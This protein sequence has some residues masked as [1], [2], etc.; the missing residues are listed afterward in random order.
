M[1]DTP[2][3]AGKVPKFAPI[4]ILIT[5]Q[6]FYT[7]IPMIRSS[8]FW[9]LAVCLFAL[10]FSVLTSSVHAKT[11]VKTRVK[12][13]NVL[14]IQLYASKQTAIVGD[15]VDIEITTGNFT[16]VE[17]MTIP[18]A[19]NPDLLTYVG[20]RDLSTAI[21]A[22]TT[23]NFTTTN[24]STGTLFLNWSG[25]P[26]S[27]EDGKPFFT[28]RFTVR[29]YSGL[30]AS[31]IFNTL[32]GLAINTSGG[33]MATITP[34]TGSV[35]ILDNNPCPPRAAGLSCQ[36]APVLNA[37]E[38]PYYSTLPVVPTPP[39]TPLT[40]PT[41]SNTC[42]ASIENNHWVAF[43]AAS[44]AL[45]L[46]IGAANSSGGGVQFFIYETNDCISFQKVFCHQGG[47]LAGESDTAPLT[48]LTIGKKYYIML[49]GQFGDRCDYT[50]AI[51]SGQVENYVQSIPTPTILGQ[52][53]ACN[54]PT[55]LTYSIPVVASAEKYFWRIP[56]SATATTPISGTNQTSITVNWG[57]VSDSVCV[58]IASRCDLS[59]WFCKS[60]K[61]GVKITK[62][63]T[64]RKCT[65][66][67]YFFDGVNRF[68]A[69]QYI[70]YF[71]ASSGCD[72]VVTLTLIN[73]PAIVKDT[74]V[75]KCAQDSYKFNG[76]NVQAEGNYEAKFPTASGCDSTVKLRLFN[77][78]LSSKS[79]DTTICSGTSII[80]GG[81]VFSAPYNSAFTALTR[82]FQGCDSIISLK[83]TVIDFLL[84]PLIKSNEITCTT[85]QATLTSVVLNQPANAT[86]SYSWKN[87]S[88]TVVSTAATATVN[89][90]GVFTL[91]VTAKVND[92]LCSK[93]ASITVTKSGNQ[94]VKPTIVG[95]NATCENSTE[96]YTSAPVPSVL[97]YNWTNSNGTFTSQTNQITA[98]WNANATSSKVCISAQNACGVSD[99]ACVSVEIGRTPQPLSI[100]GST[101]VCPNATITYRVNALPNT[102]LLWSVTG[103][104]AQNALTTDSLWVR[105]ATT[106][107]R[108]TLTPS[109]RCGNG[110]PTNLD[111]QISNIIPDSVP[112][113][114]IATPCS[115]DTTVYSVANSANI[116]DYQW[117]VPIGA[118]I[119]RGQGTRSITVVWGNFSG[120]GNVFL[121]SKNACQLARGVTFPVDVKK[122]TLPT[123]VI[124][125]N[126]T[127]CPNTQ[128]SFATPRLADIRSYAWT[129]PP[130]ATILRGANSDSIRVDWA[131]A[132]SG[133]VCLEIVTICGAKQKACATI[134]VR[135]DLDSLVISGGSTACKDSILRFC[136]PDDGSTLRFLWQI[137][138]V[139]GGTIVSGQGTSCVNIRFASS[140]G[141]VRV[142]P[143]GGCSDG[144]I[145][146]KEVGV[147]TPPSI[148]SLIT[149]KTTVCNNSVETFSVT[150]QTDILRYVWRLPS[151][152][153]FM[154]DST[155]NTLTVKISNTAASGFL[156]VQGESACGLSNGVTSRLAV[157]QRPQ[158]NAGKDTSICNMT[159]TLK[160]TTNGTVKTWSV[161]SK[162][163]GSVAT[164]AFADRSQTNVTVT[165]AGEYVFKF[166]ESNGGECSMAD[167]ITVNFRDVPTATLVDQN[168]NQE[169]TQYRVQL[170]VSG[171][172]S[173]FSIGGSVFGRFQGVSFLSDTIPSGTPYF[174][175]ITDAF[176]CKSDTVKGTK[177]CPCYTSAGRLK[178]DSLVVC[179]GATGKAL[180]QG[181]AKLDVN[182]VSEYFLHTGSST[183]IGNILARNKTGIFSF[184]PNIVTYNRVYYI[185]FVVGDQQPNGSIDTS[186]RCVSQTLGIPIIFKEQYTASLTGDT[187]VCR[188]SPVKLRFNSSQT[189][190]FD[191]N[192]QG[193][194]GGNVAIP[195]VQSPAN[196]NVNTSLSATYKLIS[197]IDKNGCRAQITDSARVNL[198]PLPNANAGVDRSVC[199]TTVQMEAAENFSYTG[200]W[201]SLTSNVV[202]TDPTD[203]RSIVTNLQNGR[204][205]FVWTVSDT[206]CL[207]YSVRDTV[208]I[209]VPLLPKANNLSLITQI[210]VPV[211]GNVSESAPIGTY[212]VTRLSNPTSGRFDLFS[213]GAFTYIPD[214]NFEG[215][216]KFRYV[217][218]S[219]LCTR[220]CD[221]GEVR[222][223]IQ[224]RKDT[225]KFIK[226]DVPNAITPN[227]DGKNDVLIIDGLDQVGENELVIF[228]RWGDVLYK[229]KPYKN[230]WRG[231][232]QSGAALPEGTY[233]YVLRL[234]T[235]DGKI[236]R[237]DIT[238]L[239]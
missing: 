222:I 221:T 20:V 151:G 2:T 22:F 148:T 118:T 233:Y 108:V 30:P 116:L 29:A 51:T 38:F 114:G 159:Y 109:S 236:L 145:S 167:S 90:G 178:A 71:T 185:T 6:N 84:Q 205:I 107:G 210:G 105:W 184:D 27:I 192:Y 136:V 43:T 41:G 162:P 46:K 174:F 68:E 82:S 206:A 209:F 180:P 120:Y 39:L 227:D 37:S 172:G 25:V 8:K 31:V 140:G 56:S 16:N 216:V 175:I 203:P 147:K 234:N 87:A 63:T 194:N 119:L 200:K 97:S 99:T 134:E 58:R 144:K 122:S 66:E 49:D 169:A 26:S 86:L 72:S 100:T 44:T 124:N 179:F 223:L 19:W 231:T 131:D 125:G 32:A 93:T 110:T 42:A 96:I 9:R 83:V 75:Y 104:T 94:P 146:R 186:K 156:T 235:A 69:K 219:D 177:D 81:R 53:L 229:S 166:E 33:A 5:N 176:G 154:G 89:Q 130:T 208:Q 128:I 23:A 4:L 102:T 213:N 126:R 112:I 3:I 13:A 47:I 50:I 117:Q 196:I 149:G 197:V 204:N 14:D 160:G 225:A 45:T 193:T 88:G 163:V 10:F 67:P 92:K 228:N 183:R 143:V 187:T 190:F 155:T 127:V 78:P 191:I 171:T 95:A 73:T 168:C 133:D 226:I 1:K 24:T 113:Q 36:T 57:T 214:P 60:V 111:V 40:I 182:D 220:L 202:I 201:S 55:G 158:V 218:C 170:N 181:D 62:D 121:T 212:S 74:T 80:I 195:N 232:N 35:R 77:Y 123:S 91:T 207:G 34:S 211:T 61:A 64:V 161:V 153:T 139:L 150:P 28:I 199:S 138:T 135:A 230:E 12:N 129:V 76:V 98:T 164:F 70:G 7:R 18:L 115:N 132:P 101:T 52:S 237:G 85:P 79:I 224:P 17:E 59:K 215:I 238:I 188:F 106:N 15:T 173:P 142:I 239:R 54:N 11:T 152:V 141:I 198:R 165:K 157:L 48:G 217:I 21:P 189:G 137:P 65:A 103:G